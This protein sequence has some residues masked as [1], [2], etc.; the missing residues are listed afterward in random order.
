MQ[1]A[2]GHRAKLDTREQTN[3]IDSGHNGLRLF[4][5]D[6]RTTAYA[7]RGAVLYLHGAAF[8]SAAFGRL[9]VRGVSWRDVLC[10]AGFDVWTL[11]FLGFGGSDRYPEMEADAD[12]H[13]PLGLAADAV[14]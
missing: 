6:L 12:A 9:P 11:D 10:G 7:R 8:P 3:P 2:D 14:A 1:S 5:R 13:A 4:L